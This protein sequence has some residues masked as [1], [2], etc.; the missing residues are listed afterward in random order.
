[1]SNFSH[2]KLYTILVLLWYGL[3]PVVESPQ[4]LK[5]PFYDVAGVFLPMGHLTARG[6]TKSPRSS[7]ILYIWWMPRIIYQHR[8]SFSCSDWSQVGEPCES[9][10]AKER[11][12]LGTVTI[13]IKYSDK[14]T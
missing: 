1:M 4:Q 12:H 2:V 13:K 14:E 3:P 10:G 11:V 7:S 5:K 8:C 9:P 6:G